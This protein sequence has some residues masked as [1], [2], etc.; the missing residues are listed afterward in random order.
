LDDQG[1]SRDESAVVCAFKEKDRSTSWA[2]AKRAKAQRKR[3]L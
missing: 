1:K 3:G 2:K